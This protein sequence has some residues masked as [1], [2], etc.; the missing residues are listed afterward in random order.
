MSSELNDLTS[1][2]S[3]SELM[4]MR[5]CYIETVKLYTITKIQDIIDDT[6]HRTRIYV[7]K[8]KKT[9]DTATFKMID[10]KFSDN[11][12]DK[13]MNKIS[14]FTMFLATTYKFLIRYKD[15]NNFEKIYNILKHNSY[16]EHKQFCNDFIKL[17]RVSQLSSIEKTIDELY[18]ASRTVCK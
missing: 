11:Y 4:A 10:Y 14:L 3:F 7:I 13:D 15:D 2:Y 5:N 1:K 12:D 6:Y 9:G 8:N 18:E 17:I 16:E